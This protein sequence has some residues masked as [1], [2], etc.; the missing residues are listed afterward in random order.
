MPLTSD[1]LLRVGHKVESLA[2]PSANDS[3]FCR[4]LTMGEFDRF[5]IMVTEAAGDE[6]KLGEARNYL[7]ACTLCNELG[8]RMFKD[9]DLASVAKLSRE[10]VEPVFQHA[11]VLNRMIRAE[12]KKNSKET[13]EGSSDSGSPS[14]SA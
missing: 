1:A 14:P 6:M 13:P 2:I 3:V 8:E 12:A 5:R 9:G 4:T 10:V 7:V 11:Q